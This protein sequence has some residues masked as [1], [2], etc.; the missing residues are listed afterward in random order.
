MSKISR[1][2]LFGLGVGAVAAT[3]APAVAAK[4]PVT[5]ETYAEA[6]RILTKPPPKEFMLH[7][8]AR[9]TMAQWEAVWVREIEGGI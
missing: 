8:G 7:A 9:L 5:A 1:R 4:V 6:V 2:A 3:T